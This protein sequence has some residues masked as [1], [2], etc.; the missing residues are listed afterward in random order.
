MSRFGSSVLVLVGLMFLLHNLGLLR[1]SQ[2][3]GFLQ[4]WWPVGLIAVGVL[5]LLGKRK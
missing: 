4:T 5:G 2:I 3:G 1:F